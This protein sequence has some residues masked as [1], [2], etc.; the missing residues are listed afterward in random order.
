TGLLK[1]GECGS[2]ITAQ[3]A[4][5]NGGTYRYYRCT[6]RR[7]KCSQSYLREDLMQSQLQEMLQM[8]ILPEG[9]GHKMIARV[10]A[11]EMEEQK[12]IIAFAQTMETKLKEI[13]Q[14]LDKLINSFLDG[15]I[16]KSAYLK[17]KDEL[18][19]LKTEIIQKRVDFGQK[20]KLWNEPLRDWLETLSN[21]DKL[22]AKPDFTEIKTFLEK[23]GTNRI[24]KDKKVCMDLVAPYSFIPI[25]KG[26]VASNELKVIKNKKGDG[27][28]NAPSPV[29]W[30]LLGSNQ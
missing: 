6:K 30:E 14:R 11:W 19:K 20:G 2:A 24:L 3:F 25:Y 18:V 27:T 7:G 23:I 8:V 1:C 29:V 17:K 21:A 28:K 9:W 5:G 10:D 16:E 4:K 22:N 15:T 26:L 12:S 13:E